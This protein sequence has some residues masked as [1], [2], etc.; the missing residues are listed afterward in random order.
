[1]KCVHKDVTTNKQTQRCDDKQTN[2]EIHATEGNS[3]FSYLYPKNAFESDH[4]Q[5][6]NI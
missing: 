1:M 5:G 2:K 3:Y 4:E 6:Y